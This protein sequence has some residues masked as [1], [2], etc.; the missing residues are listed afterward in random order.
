MTKKLPPTQTPPLPPNQS[1][2]EAN[3]KALRDIEKKLEAKK[4]TPKANKGR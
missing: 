3:K 2:V 1:F 4:K